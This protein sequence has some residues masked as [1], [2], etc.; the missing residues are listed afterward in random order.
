M[1]NETVKVDTHS[2]RG[3]GAMQI[4]L[5][6]TQHRC[7]KFYRSYLLGLIGDRMK[8]AAKQTEKA[9]RNTFSRNNLHIADAEQLADD[10]RM[11]MKFGLV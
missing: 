2:E 11:Y 1:N 10:K 4:P 6:R 8:G 3:C 7:L 5:D 9:H